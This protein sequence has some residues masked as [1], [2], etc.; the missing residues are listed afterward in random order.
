VGVIEPVLPRAVGLY[1]ISG[2]R[3]EYICVQC[4]RMG[5]DAG[6]GLIHRISLGT[7]IREIKNPVVPM[8][9]RRAERSDEAEAARNAGTEP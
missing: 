8:V 7:T 3:L 6:A 4:P 2:E 5:F 9:D 1:S